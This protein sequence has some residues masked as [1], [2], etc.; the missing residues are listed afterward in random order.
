MY[1][2]I[3]S[4]ILNADRPIGDLMEY[5]RIGIPMQMIGSGRP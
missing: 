3:G 5:T 4:G 2:K 1:F